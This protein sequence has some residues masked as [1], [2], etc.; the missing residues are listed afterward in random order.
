M[1]KT[2]YGL[3]LPTRKRDFV[4]LVLFCGHENQCHLWF[5]LVAIIKTTMK[6]RSDN[7]INSPLAKC[8]SAIPRSYGIGQYLV[9]FGLGIIV[10][11]LVLTLYQSENQDTTNH[12]LAAAPVQDV[13]KH[14][15]KD[16][17]L[18]LDSLLRM[19]VD[20]LARLDLARLNLLCAEGLPGAE[21]LD[22]A[23]CLATLDEWTNRVRA[24]TEKY[25][26]RFH[27]KPAEY[28]NSEGYFRMLALITVLQQDCGVRYNPER[29]REVDFSDSG[30]LFLHGLLGE[31]RT[32]TCVSLPVL[33]VALGR[34]L[35][36][37]LKLVTTNGHIFARWQST[38]GKERFNI[39]GT[40]QGLSCFEDAYYQT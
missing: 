12:L 30:D 3:Q 22:V 27:R 13:V 17:T 38:D 34:R 21:K 4:P 6:K 39:E 7:I 33:Y 20:E 8:K 26:Y 29:I 11:F 14:N 5:L 35:G 15:T 31:D 24:E 18:S 1:D 10:C 37:P 25:L 40:N 2:A 23:K 32:G 36:Y 19:S 16:K 28:N 9:V